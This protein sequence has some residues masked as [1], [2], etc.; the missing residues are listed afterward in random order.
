MGKIALLEYIKMVIFC[1]NQFSICAYSTINKF[2]VIRVILYKIEVKIRITENDMW[3]CDQ[4][5]YN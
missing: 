2:I 5:V 4:I 1:D 3:R